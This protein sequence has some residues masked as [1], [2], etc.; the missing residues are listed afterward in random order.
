M[1]TSSDF[2]L[3]IVTSG[4]GS[5][6]E[7]RPMVAG[8]D[9]IAQAD[10]DFPGADPISVLLAL[11]AGDEPHEVRL[12]EAE[13][14]ELCCGALHVTIRR[15][16]DQVVWGPWRNTSDTGTEFEEVRFDAVAYD[17]ELR[18]VTEDHSWEWP[19]RTVARLL[20]AE[21]RQH[22]DHF[23]AW[24]CELNGVNCLDG[25]VVVFTYRANQR[26]R[27]DFVLTDRPPAEQVVGLAGLVLA[28]DPRKLGKAIG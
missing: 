23:A 25:V 1:R 6:V 22:G 19:A 28:G 2:Q 16:A 9:V 14:T 3:R 27:I 17:A 15:D 8:A 7:V 12:A 18:R 26:F 13:C 5:L 10:N 20:E 24:D 11:Q 21:L 4:P